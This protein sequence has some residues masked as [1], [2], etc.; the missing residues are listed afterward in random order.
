MKISPSEMFRSETDKYSSFD[1][2]V[3]HI[4]AHF[5]IYFLFKSK[6]NRIPAQI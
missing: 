6:P 5:F 3:T 2:M 1:E 4:L